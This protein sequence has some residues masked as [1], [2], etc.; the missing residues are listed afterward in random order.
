MSILDTAIIQLRRYIDHRLALQEPYRSTVAGTDGDLVRITRL[1]ASTADAEPSAKVTLEPLTIGD[2]VMVQPVLGKPVVVGKV[3]RSSSAELPPESGSVSGKILVTGAAGANWVDAGILY[4]SNYSSLQTALDAAENRNNDG[5]WGST[6]QTRHGLIEVTAQIVV[7]ISVV[8]RG[9]GPRATELRAGSGFP[10]NTPLVRLGRGTSVAE[11]GIGV[12]DMSIHCNYVTGSTGIFTDS[13]HEP[14][15]IRRVI[16][17]QYMSRGIWTKWADTQPGNYTQHLLIEDSEVFAPNT[18]AAVASIDIGQAGNPVTVRRT[19][20]NAYAPGTTNT[21]YAIRAVDA[22]LIIDAC[23]FEEHNVGIRVEQGA[24]SKGSLILLGATGHPTLTRMVEIDGYV[25]GVIM[26]LQT[27]GSPEGV[28]HS[29]ANGGAGGLIAGDV[30]F[31]PLLGIG[32]NI[33]KSVTADFTG[34]FLHQP[35]DVIL[36]NPSAGSRWIVLPGAQFNKGRSL[37]YKRIGTNTSNNVDI[38][39]G[40]GDSIDGVAAKR[41]S[42]GPPNAAITVVS[43]GNDWWITSQVGTVTDTF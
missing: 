2:E 8:L 33:V 14:S 40:S 30:A 7:P 11:A 38:A 1:G 21:P 6:V 3:R 19:T 36:I 28:W 31:M 4:A 22:P 25:S 29:E 37:T 41:L 18:G 32:Q 12:E 42:W 23:H 34:P 39:A 10:A 17:A 13:A 24:G 9:A 15:A 16:V 5:R 35:E 43:D 26:G 27:V 20:V